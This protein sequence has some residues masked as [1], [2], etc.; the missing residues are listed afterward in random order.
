M[1]TI[2][3]FHH[4]FFIFIIILLLL[5]LQRVE[6]AKTRAAAELASLNEDVLKRFGDAP[7]IQSQTMTNKVHI[8]YTQMNTQDFLPTPPSQNKN[9]R[10]GQKS[11]TLAPSMRVGKYY[12]EEAYIQ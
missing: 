9:I 7:L 12:Y 10:Y 2:F 3:S 8:P 5:L 6:E 4:Y 1:F 11:K